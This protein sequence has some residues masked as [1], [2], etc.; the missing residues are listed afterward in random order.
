MLRNQKQVWE[1]MFWPWKLVVFLYPAFPDYLATLWTADSE[2]L[3]QTYAPA[4]CLASISPSLHHALEDLTCLCR[5]D[6]VAFHCRIQHLWSTGFLPL[7]SSTC[8]P[9]HFPTQRPL[10]AGNLESVLPFSFLCPILPLLYFHTGPSFFSHSMAVMSLGTHSLMCQKSTVLKTLAS[11]TSGA[12]PVCWELETTMLL[13]RKRPS[14]HKF[15]KK[16]KERE[17]NVTPLFSS[18]SLPWAPGV[19]KDIPKQYLDL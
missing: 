14:T 7:F 17:E 5:H 8:S 1:G 16:R 6:S 12:C 19:L 18:P 15:K 4:P 2:A 10:D 11:K 13:V 3:S 9:S